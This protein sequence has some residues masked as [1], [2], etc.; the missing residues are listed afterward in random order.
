[1]ATVGVTWWPCSA[2]LMMRELLDNEQRAEKAGNWYLKP[3]LESLVDIAMAADDTLS[4][5]RALAL[6][7][8][9]GAAHDP[10][11]R[12]RGDHRRIEW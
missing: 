8:G 5:E 3:Y 4:P 10:R 1:M 2:R 7:S 12:S 9:P 11:P 6:A